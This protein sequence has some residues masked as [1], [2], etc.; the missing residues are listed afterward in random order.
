MKATIIGSIADL[1][2][3]KT[4]AVVFSFRPSMGDILKTSAKG[5][6]TIQINPASKKSLSKGVESLLEQMK[7]KMVVGSVQ[8]IRRD[9]H[10]DV[11]DIE[12]P[13]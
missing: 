11:I 13:K 9:K 7:M 5:I 8:G 2:N 12:V 6:K 1:D 10:G 3:V 4:K